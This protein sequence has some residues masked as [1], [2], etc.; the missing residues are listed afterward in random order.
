MKISWFLFLSVTAVLLSALTSCSSGPPAPNPEQTKILSAKLVN[1]HPR[2]T[3]AHFT[4]RPYPSTTRTWKNEALL[5]RA[6]PSNTKVRIDL[7]KQRGFLLVDDQIAM[8]YRVSSGSSKYRTPTGS[9]K[10]IEKTRSKSSN[11]YGKIR[12]SGGK[13][14]ITDADTRIHT[15]PEGGSFE[16]ASMPYWMRLTRSGIGM[17]QGD[18]KRTYA[19]HGCIRTHS[20]AVG[21]VYAKT[22]IGT[23]VQ[24]VD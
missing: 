9:Y 4:Y 5:A 20:S 23:P 1:P 17:H 8:D 21:I 10:I 7:S 13:V 14:V 3:Y 16:G 11:L 2:G 12:D 6:N 18:V 24:V 15:V 22:G 19:S